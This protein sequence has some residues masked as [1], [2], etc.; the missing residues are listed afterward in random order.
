MGVCAMGVLCVRETTIPGRKSKLSFITWRKCRVCVLSSVVIICCVFVVAVAI[1][2]IG[3]IIIIIII[4]LFDLEEVPT[5]PR[6][7]TSLSRSLSIF[8]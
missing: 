6:L 2:I 1:V 8:L 5:L 4:S 7:G 3:I